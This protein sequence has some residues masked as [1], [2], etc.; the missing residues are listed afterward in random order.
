MTDLESMMLAKRDSMTVPTKR[1][2][3]RILADGG[4]SVFP[5]PNFAKLDHGFSYRSSTIDP[6]VWEVMCED[7]MRRNECLDVNV[8]LAPAKC[9]VP[10][11]VIDLDGA[12]SIQAF[13]SNAI[14]AGHVDV[15]MWMRVNTTRPDH[16]RHVYFVSPEG[17][18]FGNSKHK[19]GGEVRSA[20]GH[21]V[22]PPSTTELGRYT[23]VGEK[24]YEAPQWVLENLRMASHS[25]DHATGDETVEAILQAMSQCEST[26]YGEVG[27][28]NMLKELG[29]AR[30]G[31]PQGGRN[32]TLSKVVNRVLDLALERHLSAL[33]ALSEVQRV[34][35]SLFS[36]D[37]MQARS[38]GG[39]FVRC[40]HSWIRNKED[41]DDSIR[42]L[43]GVTGF[44]SSRGEVKGSTVDPKIHLLQQANDVARKRMRGSSAFNI[45]K[46]ENK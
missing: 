7:I 37:E 19:W 34:Y 39:E 42:S 40:V 15:E 3:G 35:V 2:A 6:G 38:P 36:V 16:G 31:S 26:S 5:V 46:G 24:L 23:W 45:F 28:A 33:V 14:D 27:L 12:A 8:C 41:L 25:G 9:L 29:D 1:E 18:R 22:M 20:K 17:R 21:V 30:P 13:F 43:E 32:P 44:L 11:L 4:W 10:L